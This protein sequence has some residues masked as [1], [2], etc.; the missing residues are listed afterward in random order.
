MVGAMV[1]TSGASARYKLASVYL[2]YA[3]ANSIVFTWLD[4]ILA[5]GWLVGKV[6]RGGWI[7]WEE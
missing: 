5:G 7:N 2:A 3:L 6:L 4:I 1:I